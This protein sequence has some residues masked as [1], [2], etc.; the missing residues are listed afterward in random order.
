MEKWQNPET[1]AI[2]IV[3]AVVFFLVILIF[4]TVLLRAF[5]KKLVKAK[6]A[7]S[8]AET[9]HQQRLLD[10]TIKTQ[11]IERVR[12]AED[13]HD[14]LIGKLMVIKLQQEVHDGASLETLA[15]IKESIRIARRISHDLSPPLL[16]FTTLSDL[17][18]EVLDP[19]KERFTLLTKLDLSLIHI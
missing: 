12:I 14:A 4:I 2:W 8:K 16:E 7:E 17:L 19:W 11:E 18:L 10:T 5:L 3:I 15:L 1:I 6:L 9:I 13:L